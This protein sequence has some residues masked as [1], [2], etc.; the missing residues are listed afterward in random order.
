MA[1][2]ENER[3]TELEVKSAFAEDM[4]DSLNTTV[5][6]QQQQIDRLLREVKELREQIAATAPAEG[7]SL[8]DEIPPH[9]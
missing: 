2:S 1:A 9:Y 3:L 7:R 5:Y 8:R 6:R 4:L